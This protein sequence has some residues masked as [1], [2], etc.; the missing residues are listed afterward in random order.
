M[1]AFSQIHLCNL[2]VCF[3]F[4]CVFVRACMHL[5]NPFTHCDDV[6]YTVF[7]LHMELGWC[8]QHSD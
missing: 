5:V 7:L 4:L 8:I 1:L 2:F 3:L 6:L